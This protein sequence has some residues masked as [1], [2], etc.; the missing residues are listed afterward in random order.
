[1]M[2]PKRHAIR[3]SSCGGKARGED[4]TSLRCFWWPPA[5]C[6]EQE[7]KLPDLYRDYRFIGGAALIL[8]GAGNWIVGLSRT[9]QYGQMIA[10]ASDRAALEEVYRNFDELDANTDAAVLEPFVAEQRKVSYATARMDFYHATFLTGQVLL[11]A[12]LVLTSLGVIAVIRADAHRATR[13]EQGGLSRLA[14]EDQ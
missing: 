9:E 8:L 4:S 3:T 5:L 10:K 7:M 11:V 1:M 14:A 13:S 6:F 12:G 2:L